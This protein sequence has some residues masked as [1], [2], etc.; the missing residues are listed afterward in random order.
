VLRVASALVAFL[1]AFASTASADEE[2]R[3]IGRDELQI[4]GTNI[5]S[6]TSYNGLQYVIVTPLKHGDRNFVAE[7]HF[8]IESNE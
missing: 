2:Y 7:A 4:L 3:V 8:R 5:E 1:L 6:R